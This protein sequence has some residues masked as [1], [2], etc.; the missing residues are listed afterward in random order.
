M[1]SLVR[2]NEEHGERNIRP[3]RVLHRL[4]LLRGERMALIYGPVESAIISGRL[5]R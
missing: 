1:A 2:H 5:P 3:R 4:V